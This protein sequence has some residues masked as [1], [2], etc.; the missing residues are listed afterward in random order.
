MQTKEKASTSYKPN[1]PAMDA[2]RLVC[3]PLLLLWR[4]K[5]LTPDGEKYTGRIQG[6]AIVAANHTSFADPFLV[7]VAFWYRRLFF[8]AAEAVMGGKLRSWLLKG[9]GA[10]KIDRNCADIDS[11]RKCV[12]VL[13]AGYLLSVFPQGGIAAED[14][15]KTV[16]SGAIL[17]ALQAGVPIVPMYICPKRRWYS[18]RTVVIGNPIE[19][20]DYIAKKFPST[21]DIERVSQILMEKMNHCKM[22]Q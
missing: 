5:R 6:G 16:K 14:E 18:R 20:R 19:P 15:I 13:K 2:A 22:H 4:M 12:D 1:L 10:I 3:T 21:K 8:L 9:V 17:M 7:G 11:L